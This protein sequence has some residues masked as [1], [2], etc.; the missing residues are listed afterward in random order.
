MVP[1]IYGATDMTFLVIFQPFI[2]LTT[3]K[4]KILKLKNTPSFYT[5]APTINDNHLMYGS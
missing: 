2:P 3:R 5:F 1:E 4:I